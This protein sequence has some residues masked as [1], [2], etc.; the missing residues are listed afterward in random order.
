ML[1]GSASIGLNAATPGVTVGGSPVVV[2]EEILDETI[3]LTLVEQMHANV[4]TLL[5]DNSF[6]QSLALDA[7]NNWMTSTTTESFDVTDGTTWSLVN[8]FEGFFLQDSD[9]SLIE[10]GF[11]GLENDYTGVFGF[12]AT[13]GLAPDQDQEIFSLYA[14]DGFGGGIG[15]N[16]ISNDGTDDLPLQ[17]TLKVVPGEGTQFVSFYQDD[18]NPTNGVRNGLAFQ[19]DVNRFRIFQEYT[20]VGTEASYSSN[21]IF[22]VDNRDGTSLVDYDDGLF[23]VRAV[24]AP[25]VPEPSVIG[26]MALGGLGGIVL[27]RRRR[28]ANKA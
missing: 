13:D 1:A 23:Y 3:P 28:A 11:F 6:Y 14:T 22:A 2:T 20:K 5:G 19:S 16:I 27:F 25:I 24:N 4:G 21:Y 18:T 10:V 26:L 15:A 8:N 7:S 12:T 9:N 17:V